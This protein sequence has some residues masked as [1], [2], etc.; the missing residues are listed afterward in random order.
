[1][2][3]INLLFLIVIIFSCKDN[4]HSSTPEFSIKKTLHAEYVLLE[5]IIAPTFFSIQGGYL[6][7]Y[8]LR[9]DTIID[10]FSLPDLSH[11]TSFG[12]KGQGPDEFQSFPWPCRSTGND[13]YIRGY[14]PLTIKQLYLDDGANPIEKNKFTLTTYETFSSMYIINDSLLVYPTMGSQEDR[15][16]QIAIKKINL[17]RNQEIGKILIHTSRPDNA[18]LDPNRAGGFDVNESFIV[19][20]YLFR[21]QIDIYN[22][23]DMKL[24]KRL[25]SVCL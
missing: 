10:L 4:K 18:S 5:R 1:M 7:T 22:L 13:I 9:K 3:R 11:V 8:S 24:V 12:T 15:K 19:Y 16:E 17:N 2:N 14:T 23:H 25:N 20:A 21:K 6:C